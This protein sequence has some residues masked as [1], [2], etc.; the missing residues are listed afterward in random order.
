VR[1][2]ATSREALGIEGE[3]RW[4]VA[5]LDEAE[6]IQLFA[7]RASAL[8]VD[9]G[10]D[11]PLSETVAEV[12]RRLDGIPLAI[13]LA[14]AQTRVLATAEI[15]DRL[16]DRFR[17]L[18]GRDRT[19]PARQQTLKAAIDWSHDLLTDTE[20][21]LFRRLSVFA[22]GWTLDAVEAVVGCQ[23]PVAGS[24]ATPGDPSS[25][26][27]R[28]DTKPVTGNRQS[29]T[30][31]VVDALFRLVDKSLVVAGHGGGT[32]RYHMHEAVREYARERLREAGEEARV[33]AAHVDWFLGLAERVERHTRT[34]DERE[35]IALLDPERDNLRVAIESCLDP[36][37][38]LRLCSALGIYWN[39]RGYVAEA[40]RRLEDA[41]ARSTIPAS[42]SRAKALYWIGDL[43]KFNSDNDAAMV[44]FEESVAICRAIDDKLGLSHALYA[45]GCA[46]MYAE[47]YERA[48]EVSEESRAVAEEIGDWRRVAWAWSTLGC[49]AVYRGD[50]EDA[51]PLLEKSLATF[52]R[53]GCGVDVAGTLNNL[54]VVARYEGNL[55]QAEVWLSEGE[56]IARR[57]G[58]PVLVAIS[59]WQ[60]GAMACVR[61]Q[62]DLAL[63]Y[64]E[65]AMTV[66][67]KHGY[68]LGI[69][70]VLESAAPLFANLGD[71]RRA[72]R[73]E[74][75]ARAIRETIK[76]PPS[77]I[78][79]AELGEKLAGA[80]RALGEDAERAI[81]EGRALE[82]EEAARLAVERIE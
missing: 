17:L 70:L 39:R 65:E 26:T 50:S 57:E 27:G 34:P 32:T 30:V 21:V 55:E 59:T 18:R 67:L 77:P 45:L 40:R 62:L 3:T 8:G 9:L 36:E 63:S 64:F 60:R 4:E 23:L 20:A 16:D 28:A 6:S 46:L 15:L 31:D 80:R 81:E 12:C 58:H 35:W 51:I 38:R 19:A 7:S 53:I 25:E 22:G 1:V 52:R 43:H 2:L 74:G 79:R 13:E 48:T 71:A 5:P 10:L 37:L 29:E 61:K 82:V 72:L 68:L 76:I 69:V 66:F 73:L 54:A 56:E 49:I 42:S 33:V 44:A 24:G 41:L 47:E 78:D 11:G 14:A 75:A